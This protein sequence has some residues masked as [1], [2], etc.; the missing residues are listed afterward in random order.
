MG[1][2][3]RLASGFDPR[4]INGQLHFIHHA[5][6]LFCYEFQDRVGSDWRPRYA[7]FRHAQ[8]ADSQLMHP[9]FG[10][11]LYFNQDSNGLWFSDEECARPLLRPTLARRKARTK[12]P[13]NPPKCQIPVERR[14]GQVIRLLLNAGPCSANAVAETLDMKLRT[15]QYQLNLK[16]SSYQ[17]LYNSNRLDLARYYIS[18]SELS[19]SAIADRL[20]FVDSAAFSNFFRAR[21][22]SSPRDYALRVRNSS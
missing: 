12:L 1:F 21:T 16:G 2:E 17:T 10:E 19:I 8:P 4:L 5:M 20:R 6:A 14:V 9:V 13:V 7:Q 11:H 15:M 22:G 3:F 18:D